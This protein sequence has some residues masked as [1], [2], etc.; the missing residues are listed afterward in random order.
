MPKV[1][2]SK[3]DYST[4]WHGI[5]GRIIVGQSKNDGDRVRAQA[6]SNPN[7]DIYCRRCLSIARASKLW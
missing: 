6:K 3:P 1:H 2:L 5:C 4:G 7:P